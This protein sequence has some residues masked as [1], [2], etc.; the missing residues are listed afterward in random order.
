MIKVYAL[1]TCPQ[2]KKLKI[3]L[4]EKGINYTSVD[5]DKA[6][7]EEKEQIL[8]KIDQLVNNR[9]F[10]ITV[11]NETVIQGYNPNRIEEE[12]KHGS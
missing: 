6:T 5:V 2:C 1:S 7:G 11:V 10:P 9:S 3:L 8:K 4:D 12:L